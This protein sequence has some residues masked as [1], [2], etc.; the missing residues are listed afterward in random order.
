MCLKLIQI[1]NANFRFQMDSIARQDLKLL[2]D[3]PKLSADSE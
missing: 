1:D 2:I 3:E